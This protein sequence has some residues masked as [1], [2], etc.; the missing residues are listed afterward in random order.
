MVTHHSFQSKEFP[1][2]IL[3]F[4]VELHESHVGDVPEEEDER[5]PPLD[6]VVQEDDHQHDQSQG[7][8]EHISDQRPR[9]QATAGGRKKHACT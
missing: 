7:V 8:E 4:L 1:Q 2:S 6:E 3:Y 5:L 9:R